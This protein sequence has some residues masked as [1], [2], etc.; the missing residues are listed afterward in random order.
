MMVMVYEKVNVL[1]SLKFVR[2][3]RYI[4]LPRVFKLINTG[5]NVHFTLSKLK[6]GNGTY[7]RHIT[8]DKIEYLNISFIIFVN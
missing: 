5:K 8:V 4:Y 2:N 3:T 7:T 6:N 1:F